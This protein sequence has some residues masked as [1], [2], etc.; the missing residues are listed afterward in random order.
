MLTLNASERAAFRVP[1]GLG[2][3]S[4]SIYKRVFK[5]LYGVDKGV[6]VTSELFKNPFA[7]VPII[8]ARLRAK[9]EEWRFT[10]VRYIFRPLTFLPL[11]DHSPARM[12]EGVAEPN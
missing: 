2:G 4:T 10:Q 12:G 7:V 8:L 6:E 5:K 9:D 1:T 11:A 3:Q